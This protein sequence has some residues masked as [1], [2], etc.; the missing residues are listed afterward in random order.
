MSALSKS[1]IEGFV[2]FYEKEH[3]PEADT[4]KAQA[5]QPHGRTWK[6][7]GEK[8]LD[9]LLQPQKATPKETHKARTAAQ[10]QDIVTLIITKLNETPEDKKDKVMLHLSQA[11]SVLDNDTIKE[12]A[13]KLKETGADIL[14]NLVQGAAFWIAGSAKNATLSKDDLQKVSDLFTISQVKPKEK[15]E[16]INVTTVKQL[17]P[18]EETKPKKRVSFIDEARKQA[19][20]TVHQYPKLSSVPEGESFEEESLEE[21]SF[22]E[23]AEVNETITEP[24]VEEETPPETLVTE[25]R[26]TVVYEVAVEQPHETIGKEFDEVVNKIIE[27]IANGRTIA[28]VIDDNHEM[29]AQIIPLKEA[30]QYEVNSGAAKE[31]VF[32]DL[33]VLIDSTCEKTTN[34]SNTE[35]EQVHNTLKDIATQHGF[36]LDL[37]KQKPIE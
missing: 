26:S 1:Q 29:F 5:Q 3:Q 2:R 4:F 11:V 31:E 22:E 8:E 33:L 16:S 34:L 17:T 37:E 19:L 12:L 25:S 15:R 18:S 23:I 35:Y 14:V 36:D 32:K 27:V 28:D 6:K 20:E 9:K 30:L 24:T 21:E 13:E 7:Q 10:H